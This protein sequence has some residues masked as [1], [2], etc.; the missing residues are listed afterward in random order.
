MLEAQVVDNGHLRGGYRERQEAVG[1]NK[2]V[3]LNLLK[4]VGE[5]HLV[6]VPPHERIIGRWG[7]DDWLN[8][9][10]VDVVW[11]VVLVENEVELV[12][13]ISLYDSAKCLVHESSYSIAV[14][15]QKGFGVNRYFH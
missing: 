8:I 12:F 3:G 5:Q 14:T 4:L 11:L 15:L 1:R 7:D 6:P 13:G 2:H 9:L 10:T